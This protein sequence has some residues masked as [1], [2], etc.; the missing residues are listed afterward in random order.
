MAVMTLKRFVV[1][2]Q[3]D[4]V[5]LCSL[6]DGTLSLL[7]NSTSPLEMN[8]LLSMLS[9]LLVIIDSSPERLVSLLSQVS[10][11]HIM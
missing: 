3:D 5:R 7:A 4:Y 1:F 6:F 2:F 10:F 11:C 8:N 9:A